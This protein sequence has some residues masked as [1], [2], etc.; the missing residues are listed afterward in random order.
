MSVNLV[1][2]SRVTVSV[3]GYDFVWN[4]AHTVNVFWRGTNV[5]V[6]SLD[7]GRDTFSWDEIVEACAA[8]N[9][10]VYS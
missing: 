4:G 6:F 2:R 1:K 5:D 7:Y 9:P 10:V 3:N 8:Y